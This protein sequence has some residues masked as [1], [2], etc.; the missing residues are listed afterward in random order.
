MN[1]HIHKSIHKYLNMYDVQYSMNIHI[2]PMASL[3]FCYFSKLITNNRK[4]N[5]INIMY[6]NNSNLIKLC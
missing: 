3:F 4:Y 2:P 1:I 5:N 6:K